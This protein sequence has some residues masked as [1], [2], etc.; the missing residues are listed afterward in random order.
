MSRTEF[1]GGI[2]RSLLTNEDSRESLQMMYGQFSG[3]VLYSI[4]SKDPNAPLDIVTFGDNWFQLYQSRTEPKNA[5]ERAVQEAVKEMNHP[6]I[7]APLFGDMWQIMTREQGYTIRH[8][9]ADLKGGVQAGSLDPRILEKLAVLDLSESQP[10][11]KETDF[12]EGE[13]TPWGVNG[14]L[15]GTGTLIYH[16]TS[17]YPRMIIEELS[18]DSD[19]LTGTFYGFGPMKWE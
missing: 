6:M 8:L 14:T 7:D 10:M 11:L 12:P 1:E 16:V 3:S 9:L 4:H 17:G 18:G 13:D 5:Q 15:P 2:P 19:D